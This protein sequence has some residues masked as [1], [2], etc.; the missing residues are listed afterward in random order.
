[1]QWKTNRSQSAQSVYGV[2]KWFNRDKGFGF[3][4]KDGGDDIF[5]HFREIKGTRRKVLFEGQKVKFSV[6]QSKKGPQAID[7]TVVK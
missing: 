1:M 4:Q 3:I 7:V 2:V 6:S 5:V